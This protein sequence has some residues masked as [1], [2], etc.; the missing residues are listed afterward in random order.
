MGQAAIGAVEND[1]NFRNEA[2]I[3][4]T[5]SQSGVDRDESGRPPHEFD[6]AYSVRFVAGGFRLGHAYGLL[7]RLDR[8]SETEGSVDV[9]DVVVDGFG[10]AGDGHVEALIPCVCVRVRREEGGSRSTRRNRAGFKEI[11]I[12]V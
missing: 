2:E 1:G 12:R 10:D 8:R 5:G 9:V 11:S 6:D 7:G 3:D 4:V